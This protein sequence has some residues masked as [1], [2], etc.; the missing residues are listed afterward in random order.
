M[1]LETVENTIAWGEVVGRNRRFP[2][3]LE[4]SG[5]HWN[6]PFPGMLVTNYDGADIR[7][8]R[9]TGRDHFGLGIVVAVAPHPEPHGCMKWLFTIIWNW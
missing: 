2:V 9:S 7:R 4:C 3:L 5:K 6:D 8:M 1:R